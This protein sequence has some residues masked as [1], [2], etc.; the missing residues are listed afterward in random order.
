MALLPLSFTACGDD[1]DILDKDN[2]ESGS[3][4]TQ[5]TL[6]VPLSAQD[7]C[8]DW[9]LERIETK[10]GEVIQYNLLFSVTDP[11]ADD[12][13]YGASYDYTQWYMGESTLALRFQA[14]EIFGKGI[15]FNFTAIA[16]F[17]VPLP[18]RMNS[19]FGFN[20]I[21]WD[22]ASGEFVLDGMYVSNGVE[23]HNCSL[24]FKKG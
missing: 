11:I 6:W 21:S 5:E 8:G 7:F 22:K 9:V 10:S 16:G 12:S 19:I 15:Y 1:D 2:V 13:G 4:D 20:M 3:E 23:E 24:Y 17:A 14:F 18:M